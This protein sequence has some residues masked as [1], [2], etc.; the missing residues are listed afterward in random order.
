MLPARLPE[1]T[2]TTVVGYLWRPVTGRALNYRVSPLS[3]SSGTHSSSS[4]HHYHHHHFLSLLFSHQRMGRQAPTLLIS[5]LLLLQPLIC[6][7]IDCWR[8]A[9]TLGPSKCMMS[10]AL[11]SPPPS[12][13]TE[14]N[15]LANAQCVL[16][17]RRQ[18]QCRVLFFCCT[19]YGITQQSG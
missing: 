8:L 7:P 12:P 5:P 14:V 4:G 10:P 13:K 17:R 11:R 15:A 18:K 9:S 3:S 19:H 16:L 1:N 2:T 6:L